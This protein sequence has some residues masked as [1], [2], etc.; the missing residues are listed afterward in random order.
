MN[1]ISSNT[2]MLT[3]AVLSITFSMAINGLTWLNLVGSIIGVM[4]IFTIYYGFCCLIDNRIF[5]SSNND[6]ESDDKESNDKESNDKESKKMMS[7]DVI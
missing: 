1:K 4:I 5:I 7:Y 6:K 2:W 3:V